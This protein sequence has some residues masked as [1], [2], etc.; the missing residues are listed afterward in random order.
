M[1]TDREKSLKYITI[2]QDLELNG[3]WIPAFSEI[4][5][6]T[7]VDDGDKNFAFD[8]NSIVVGM[9]K[10]IL[11]S[12]TT[13]EDRELYKACLM[14]DSALIARLDEQRKK[15]SADSDIREFQKLDE[16]L[17]LLTYLDASELSF[18]NSIRNLINLILDPDEEFLEDRED[19]EDKLFDVLTRG[20][21][22]YPK[23]Y[24]ILFHMADYH[25]NMQNYELAEK[26]LSKLEENS[27]KNKEVDILRED[28]RRLKKQEEDILYIYD[29]INLN[30]TDKAIE[31]ALDY[32][33][34]DP[35]DWQVYFLLGWAY[36][37]KEE[38]EKAEQ[39]FFD[40]IKNG[41]GDNAE[42]FNELSLVAYNLD[43][44]ALACEYSKMAS[45]LDEESLT[46]ASNCA[47]MCLE[48]KDY[49]SAL[50]HINRAFL[51]NPKDELIKDIIKRYEKESG[52]KFVDPRKVQKKFMEEEKKRQKEE[53]KHKKSKN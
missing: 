47:L 20:L 43:K 36:R 33:K 9:A 53:Q 12:K 25:K 35:K 27:Y 7:D 22:L 50:S 1:K 26:Y 34:E 3:V 14:A 11:D 46:Y 51:L 24:S 29:L 16:S 13:D 37:I 40:S 6:W 32:I 4:P 41:G 39:A 38:Y 23:S 17:R 49:E 2:K 19:Y 5:I 18:I 31:K 44:K 48:Q 42:T 15:L 52:D 21:K 8:R 10:A 45:D 28:I 30:Q